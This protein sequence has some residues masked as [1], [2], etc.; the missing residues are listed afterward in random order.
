MIFGAET[1][2]LNLCQGLNELYF[3]CIIACFQDPRIKNIELIEEAKKFK[4]QTEIIRLRNPFDIRAI[5][6]LRK[7]IDKYQ[8]NI[9]HCHDYKSDVIGFLTSKFCRIK[10]ISTYHGWTSVNVKVKLYEFLDKMVIKKFNKIIAVSKKSEKFLKDIGI[11]EKKLIV[12]ENAI[13]QAYFQN[14]ESAENFKE[15]L[16]IPEDY[17]IVSY[18]GRLSPEKGLKYFIEAIPEVL[19]A[20]PLTKFL[21]VGDGP[22]KKELEDLAI[23]LNIEKNVIFTGRR[24]KED[25]KKIYSLLDIFV[26]PSL[27]ETASLVVMEA[28][29]M[30]LPVVATQVDGPLSIIKDGITGL[31]V[32]PKNSG[33]I[34]RKIINLLNDRN[35]SQILARAAQD[36]AKKEF[37]LSKMISK[38]EEIYKEVTNK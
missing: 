3:N 37:S 31:L 14:K 12:V 20:A 19:K 16:A 34:A 33:A 17:S 25:M 18:V 30:G 24:K 13:D 32:P 8:I 35:K 2:I 5:F 23:S 11:P 4:I 27:K 29:T 15:S 21:I 22:L 6:L 7:L 28:M 36:Y 10:L 9:L 1:I 38:V 26:L